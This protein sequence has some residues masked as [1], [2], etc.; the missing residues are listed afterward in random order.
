MSGVRNLFSFLIFFLIIAL[1]FTNGLAIDHKSDANI[2]LIPQK[3]GIKWLHWPFV[4]APPPPSSFFPKFP[5]P[6]IF[7][8]P[9]FLPP[10][11][12]LPSEKSVSD[13]SMDNGQNVLEKKYYCA[14]IIEACMLER[15]TLCV[16]H[17]CTF[18]YDCCTSI[19]TEFGSEECNQYEFA[20]IKN[21]CAN[22]AAPPPTDY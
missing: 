16:R 14:L 17:R 15:D 20:M 7:P 10:K 9:R 8:W 12:F 6:K 4:H 13:I 11:P 3:K 18:S 1:N 22:Q 2:A 5:F 21:E 19:N